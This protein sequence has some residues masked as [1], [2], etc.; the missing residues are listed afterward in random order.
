MAKIA[1]P[2]DYW[3]KF[4][5]TL[6]PGFHEVTMMTLRYAF[7]AGGIAMEAVYSK[8]M[9]LENEDEG[10]QAMTDAQVD[11]TN[12]FTASIEWL[13]SHQGKEYVN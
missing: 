5:A 12:N 8:I 2:T 4:L 9:D 7:F 11:V 10:A 1:M 13:R 6:P 3:D